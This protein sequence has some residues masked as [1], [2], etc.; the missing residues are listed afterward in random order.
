[1]DIYEKWE[2]LP[3]SGNKRTLTAKDVEEGDRYDQG[4]PTT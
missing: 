2:K 1:M 3:P 4:R